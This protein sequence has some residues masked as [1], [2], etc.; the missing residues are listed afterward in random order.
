MINKNIIIVSLFILMMSNLGFA[1]ID[2]TAK[3]DS[4]KNF[5]G[6]NSTKA[7]IYSAFLPGGGQFYNKKYLKGTLNVI[8][9][10]TLIGLGIHY[11]TKMNNAYNQYENTHADADYNKYARYY[12][13]QQNIIWW[14]AAL[15]FFSVLDA[16]VDA[17][18]FNY[19]EKKKRLDI[20]FEE[21][22]ISLRLKF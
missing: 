15:K 3:P 12:E 5:T 20:L 1:Q 10:V 7:I 18:L 2:K 9:E 22:K 11:H 17:K 16:F 4:I 14:F 8:A 19:E 6:R 21:S 13:K